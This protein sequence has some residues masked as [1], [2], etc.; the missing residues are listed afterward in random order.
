MSVKSRALITGLALLSAV[1]AMPSAWA[2]E[3]TINGPAPSFSHAV[4]PPG[5]P[6]IQINP[7][8][9]FRRCTSWYV[10][11]YRPSGR[12]LFPEKHCWW[13]RG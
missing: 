10:V 1:V 3:S 9:L 11:Q 6:R 7:R 2:Q 12:V 5:P 13:M 8:P 4:G